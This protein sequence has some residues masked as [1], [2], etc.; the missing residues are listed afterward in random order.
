MAMGIE[1]FRVQFPKGMD[2]NEFALKSSPRRRPGR[3]LNSA[4]WLGKGKRPTVRTIEEVVTVIEEPEPE[5]MN[6]EEPTKSHR[7]N[8]GRQ[9]KPAA[10]EEIKSTPPTGPGRER[11]FF[12]RCPSDVVNQ[13]ESEARPMPLASPADP[14]VKIEGD[15]ITVTIGPRS[16]QSV[17]LE[18]CTSPHRRGSTFG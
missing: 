5:P 3:V 10:K 1:C 17:G 11:A 16:L 13:E 14:A 12:L 18:K 9:I 7:S 15:E 4:A 8:T 2:A 6:K